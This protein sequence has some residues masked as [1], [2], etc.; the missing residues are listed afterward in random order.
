MMLTH[1]MGYHWFCLT[2]GNWIS[3]APQKGSFLVTAYLA[4]LW[5]HK[6]AA[7]EPPPWL[8]FLLFSLLSHLTVLPPGYVR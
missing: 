8:L 4:E 6:A 3:Q 1:S 7:A 5:F 2:P